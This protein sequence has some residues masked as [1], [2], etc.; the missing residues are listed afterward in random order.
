MKQKFFFAAALLQ[1]TALAAISQSVSKSITFKDQL[2]PALQLALPNESKTADQT[3]LAKLK[4]TGY[5][6]EKTGSFMNKKN[7]QEGFYIFSGVVLPELINQKLDLY[8]KV[9]D[10]NNNSTERSAVTLMVSKG[11]ENFVSEENDSATFNAAENFLNSFANKTDMYAI[12]VQIDDKKKE[13]AASEKKWQNVRNKQEEGRTKIAQLEA[14]MKNWQQEEADQQKD[15]D[16]QRSAL[17]DLE[18][19]RAGIQQ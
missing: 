15:V 10:V 8:F 17:K 11:Y 16:A 4:E 18:T 6:P 14:D 5:K 3:I 13:L 2:R 7:K 19:R 9:D 12:G 1:L